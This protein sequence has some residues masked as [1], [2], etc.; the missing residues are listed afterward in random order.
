MFRSS[1]WIALAGCLLV[2][3]GAKLWLIGHYGSAIPF[4]DQWDSEGLLLYKPY[5][6][7]TLSPSGLIEH[8]NEHRIL[9]TR[10][11][12]LGLLQLSGEWNALLDMIVDA[13]AHTATL[14]LL[15]LVLGRG[16]DT[17]GQ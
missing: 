9:F 1:V 6:T 3:L 14:G 10:L 11:F 7:G 13:L 5:L 2:V 8:H 17:A 15:I 4:W 12:G 16:L